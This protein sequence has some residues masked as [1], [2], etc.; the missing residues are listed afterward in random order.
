MRTR[1]MRWVLGS[2]LAAAILAVAPAPAGARVGDGCLALRW[3]GPIPA[4]SAFLLSPPGLEPIT[5]RPE[6]SR[7]STA[8]IEEIPSGQARLDLVGSDGRPILRWNLLV[9][10]ELTTTA[11]ARLDTGTLD[12]SPIHPD[13]FGNTQDWG[14]GDLA[15]LPG[16]GIDGARL[17]SIPVSPTDSP[18]IRGALTGPGARLDPFI[19]ALERDAVGYQQPLGNAAAWLATQVPWILTDRGAGPGLSVLGGAGSGETSWGRLRARTE[20]QWGPLGHAEA[21]AVIGG[22]RND[23]AGPLGLGND[24]LPRNDLGSIEAR[25]RVFAAPAGGLLRLHLHALGTQRNHFLQE[26]KYDAP[27]NPRQDRS[28]LT[29]SAAW[30]RPIG[31]HDLW[32]EAGYA[33]SFTETGDGRAFDRLPKYRIG[34]IDAWENQKPTEDQMY[35]WGGKVGS[36]DPPHQYNYYT[37]ELATTWTLRGEGRLRPSPQTP[38]RVGME[39]AFTTW[40]WYEHL[41]PISDSNIPPGYPD[42]QTGFYQYASYLGYTRNA[43]AHL[44]DGL[45]AAPK[46]RALALFA[47]QRVP[48]GPVQLELGARWSSFSPGQGGLRDL[49]NPLGADSSLE[50][51]DLLTERGQDGVDPRIGLFIPLGERAAAWID[52]GRT[53]ETPPLEALYISPNRLQQQASLARDG[54][55]H[56]D[57]AR[58]QVFGNPTLKPMLRDRL[59]VGLHRDLRDDVALRLTGH[60]GQV[61]DTWVARLIEA[62]K[63]SIAYYD[64]RGKQRELGVRVSLD[65]A[66]SKRS[67]LRFTWEISRRE[68]DVI[69]P[70]PLYR[71]LLSPGMPVEGTG[72][73]ETAPLAALWFDDPAVRGWFPSIFDR[74]H[75]VSAAW[76]A[77]LDPTAAPSVLGPL[78]GRADFALV[79][80]AASGR[81]YTP[82]YVEADGLMTGGVESTAL[83]PGHPIDRNGNKKLDASEI[84]SERMPWTWQVDL[85][86]QR[87]FSLFGQGWTLFLEARNLLGQRNPR[88]V[89]SATGEADDD[90]WL[91]SPDGQARAGADPARAAKFRTDYLDR[92]DDPNHYEE[93]R[94]LRAA[95]GIDL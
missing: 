62:G 63:D 33:R 70:A 5:I 88:T 55:L 13:P 22:E 59:T 69:E 89:Y 25:L 30:D 29:A 91:D 6:E 45:N 81:P 80:R 38:L 43:S 7:N 51:A 19:Y 20:G 53:R 93:G 85:G 1:K 39:A 4:G 61:S 21:E 73:R 37:Q 10:S 47:S 76:L 86:L 82:T 74:T 34:S 72:V 71:G 66:A 24:R 9:V 8:L 36:S 28:A 27:H 2:I 95:L 40:R 52:A 49:A 11:V 31:R 57:S 48:V 12:I 32:L 17:A 83:T 65:A 58:D 90:G 79:L 16:G 67:R 94:T 15:A 18:E 14:P 3:S 23:D 56:R 50:Q 64:N 75:Q 92:L 60:V 77:R 42:S 54:L 84:N 41:D 87:R 35:W 68:T 44:D 78:L 46:P 26:F